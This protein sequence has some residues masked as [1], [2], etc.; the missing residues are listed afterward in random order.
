[1]KKRFFTFLSL[2]LFAL[3]SRAAFACGPYG[4]IY[5]AIPP[6]GLKILLLTLI[7]CALLFE[8]RRLLTAIAIVISYV[9]LYFYYFFL[10]PYI[11]YIFFNQ[12]TYNPD[13]RTFIFI[14]IGIAF[15]LNTIYIF[16]DY[17]KKRRILVGSILGIVF[18]LRMVL[19]FYIGRRFPV[20]KQWRFD[21]L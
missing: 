14:W 10:K 20:R 3:L 12:V 15:A 8:E 6:T 4:T 19:F 7:V 11:F 16:T 18:L 9:G 17:S 2:L 21:V 5:P 1:M 13:K